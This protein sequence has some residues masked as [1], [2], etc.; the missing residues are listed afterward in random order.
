MTEPLPPIHDHVE[1][2]TPAPMPPWQQAIRETILAEYA[3]PEPRLTKTQRISLVEEDVSALERR[4]DRAEGKLDSRASTPDLAVVRKELTATLAWQVGIDE[5]VASTEEYVGGLPAV[6]ARLWANVHEHAI[7]IQELEATSHLAEASTG[8]THDRIAELERAQREELSAAYLIIN[9]SRRR[10]DEM[11]RLTLRQSQAIVDLENGHG[12][13][14]CVE[15]ACPPMEEVEIE[16]GVLT[17]IKEEPA[18]PQAVST[19]E[20]FAEALR[21]IAGEHCT[22]FTGVSSCINVGNRSAFAR[23]GADKWCDACIAWA[24]LHNEPLR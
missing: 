12:W 19:F 10:L 21:L 24:A 5:W 11:E 20:R 8:T 16:L 2:Q 9:D 18:T 15:V 23:Y 17:A 4:M 1:P 3:E 14:P 7:R 6:F 13:K 22:S